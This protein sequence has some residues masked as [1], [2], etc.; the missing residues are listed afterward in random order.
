LRVLNPTRDRVQRLIETIVLDFV[1]RESKERIPS[2]NFR[3]QVENKPSEPI[4]EEIDYY[5]SVTLLDRT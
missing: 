3:G 1:E 4:V 2:R 5:F